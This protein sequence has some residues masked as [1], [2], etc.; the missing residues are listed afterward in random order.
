M[1]HPQI[2][3]LV[4]D[5]WNSTYPIPSMYA[6]FTYMNGWVFMV[7][8]RKYTVRPMDPMAADHAEILAWK[9][10]QTCCKRRSRGS[11]S[12]IWIHLT[13]YRVDNFL[14]IKNWADHPSWGK[15]KK[16]TLEKSKKQKTGATWK[17]PLWHSMKSWLVTAHCG[18]HQNS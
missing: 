2:P 1:Q 5:S 12:G 3:Q 6:M 11:T 4:L 18:L 10:L 16:K 8:V 15:W 17:K 9:F 13:I 7:N 14:R